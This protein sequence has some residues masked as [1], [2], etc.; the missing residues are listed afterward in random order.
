MTR[1]SSAPELRTLAERLEFPEEPVAL[2]D[3]LVLLTEM[4]AVPLVLPLL[5]RSIAMGIY[6]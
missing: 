4:F 1:S 6:P 5:I 2:G 3:G